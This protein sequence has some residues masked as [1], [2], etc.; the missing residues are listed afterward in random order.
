[1]QILESTGVLPPKVEVSITSATE[2][3][4]EPIEQPEPGPDVQPLSGQ[5]APTAT[6]S[7]P[8]EVMKS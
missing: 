6:Q 2:E 5:D 4:T 8:E 7:V 3:P 1:M